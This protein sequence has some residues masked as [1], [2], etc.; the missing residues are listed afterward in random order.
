M[1]R[2]HN[3]WVALVGLLLGLLLVI[4]CAGCGVTT[5]TPEPGEPTEHAEESDR[6]TYEHAAWLPM[7]G[8]AYIITD[9]DTGAEYLVISGNSGAAMTVLQEKEG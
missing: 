2:K 7:V 5:E 3:P 9:H 1:N 6:F 8:N 4:L